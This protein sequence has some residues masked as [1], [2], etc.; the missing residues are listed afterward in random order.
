LVVL[1]PE[2]AVSLAA[3][4]LGRLDLAVGHAFS[5]A[6]ANLCLA[7][8][9]AGFAGGLG[10]LGNLGGLRGPGREGIRYFF[11]VAAA[12]A[13]SGILMAPGGPRCIRNGALLAIPCLAA[14]Y[15]LYS[16]RWSRQIRDRSTWTGP[17]TQFACSRAGVGSLRFGFSAFLVA[18]G[19]WG[20]VRLMGPAL[21]SPG[22]GLASPAM[23]AAA[24]GCALPE[25]AI[26]VAAGSRDAPDFAVGVLAGASAFSVTGLV[27]VAGLVSAGPLPAAAWVI[28]APVV[29]CVALL[30]V[31]F[32]ALRGGVRAAEAAT[33]VVVFLA[34][35]AAL[36]R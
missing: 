31:L 32:F 29:T 17:P 35:L 15:W 16:G 14:A 28:Q 23:I 6:A 7:T 20:I 21:A 2:A 30:L 36:L 1:A 11:V 22:T 4:R 12:A 25:A 3:A 34:Y 10:K 5:S 19:A 26:A 9:A 33:L 27:A 8:A 13:L 18:L 24:L